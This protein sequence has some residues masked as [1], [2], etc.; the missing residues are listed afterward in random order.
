MKTVSS[1]FAGATFPPGTEVTFYDK[2]KNKLHGTVQR[3]LI[4][5]ARVASTEGTFWNVPYGGME[6]TETS[7]NPT[8]TLPEIEAIGKQLIQEHEVKNKLETGWNFAFDLAPAR[9]GICRYKERQIT[10][11]VT[12]CLKATKAEIRN[13][14]LHEIAHAI[15]GP[16]HGHDIVWKNVAVK[17]GCTAERCHRVEHTIPRW[18]G[19]CGCGKQW[20][21]QRLTQRARSGLCPSCGDNIK[22]N[23]T[24]VE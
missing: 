8:M 2:T 9:A 17:I 4:R 3:L 1:D 22:W 12:Y 11:S 14:I 24:G 5:Y 10:L 23:R 21:R 19:K 15:V 7:T 6:I 18:F 20:T 13:T 16:K